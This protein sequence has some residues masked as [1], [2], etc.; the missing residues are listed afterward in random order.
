MARRLT[1]AKAA[2]FSLGLSAL[3]HG[4]LGYFLEGAITSVS[5]QLPAPFEWP[6]KLGLFVAVWAGIFFTLKTRLG[7]WLYARWDRVASFVLWFTFG[8]PKDVYSQRERVG[9]EFERSIL[10]SLHASKRIY[11]LLISGYTMVYEKEEAFLLEA[12]R[13]LSSTHDK[14]IRILLLAKDSMPWKPRAQEFVEHRLKDDN[15]G[16]DEYDALARAAVARLQSIPKAK[17]AFY[18]TQ[19][20]WRLHIFDDYI[21]ASRYSE[22]PDPEY[23]EGHRGAVTAFDPEH[24]MYDW[25]YGEFWRRCSDDWRRE[26]PPKLASPPGE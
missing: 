10:R 12:L 25:L 5:L 4:G 20:N 11:L 21:F 2:F 22:P 14:D 15:L 17:V 6:I 13:S 9:R 16:L 7:Q 3:L 24:P 19:P 23:R 18:T 8:W 1:R 26:L